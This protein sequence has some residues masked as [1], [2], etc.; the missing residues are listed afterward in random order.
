MTWPLTYDDGVNLRAKRCSS[1]MARYI[2]RISGELAMSVTSLQYSN[3]T[4]H[5]RLK[6][7]PVLL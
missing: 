7:I 2:C 4:P 3:M 5:R 6:L 1:G